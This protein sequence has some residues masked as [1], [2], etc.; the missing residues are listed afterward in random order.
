MWKVNARRLSE[1]LLSGTSGLLKGVNT[2]LDLW[3][4][5]TKT[6]GVFSPQ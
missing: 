5:F 2:G 6:S 4:Y 3:L 1:Q